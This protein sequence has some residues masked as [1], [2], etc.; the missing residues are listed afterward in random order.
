MCIDLPAFLQ[1][2]YNCDKLPGGIYRYE[3]IWIEHQPLFAER[4]YRLRPRYR[5][6]WKPSW[7]GTGKLWLCFEDGNPPLVRLAI[8][9][10]MSWSSRYP[11]L[12]L[13]H[14][15]RY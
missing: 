12:V 2:P 6:D 7:P 4:G 13:L 14:H 8:P 11:L 5:P 9:P 10:V 3:H 1:H 15:R